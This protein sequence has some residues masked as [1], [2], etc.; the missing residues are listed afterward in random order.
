MAKTMDNIMSHFLTGL[1]QCRT[2]DFV[3]YVTG[4]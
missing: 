4:C 1:K 2:I 3:T